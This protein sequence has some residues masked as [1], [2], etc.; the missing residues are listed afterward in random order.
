MSMIKNIIIVLV[1]L[2]AGFFAYKYFFVGNG[3]NS[4][5]LQDVSKGSSTS[6]AP[7]NS[8][9]VSNTSGAD[10]SGS[11]PS[12]PNNID[13]TNASPNTIALSN[14]QSKNDLYVKQLVALEVINF[15]MDIFG[16]DSYKILHD[17]NTNIPEEPKGRHNPFAPIDEGDGSFGDLGN[18][19]TSVGF[20]ITSTTTNPLTG[21]AIP[22]K[23]TTS[24]S[25]SKVDIKVTPPAVIKRTGR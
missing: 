6:T 16:D 23:N 24:A 9:Q 20:Q 19:S 1:I 10:T 5:S 15:N 4:T 3:N 17:A 25:S 13:L 21:N 22:P 8:T 14:T 2:T 12:G 7:T 11:A 18:A